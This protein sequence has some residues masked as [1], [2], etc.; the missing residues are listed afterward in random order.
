MQSD[1]VSK[2]A[3]RIHL[4]NMHACGQILMTPFLAVIFGNTQYVY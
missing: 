4:V 1:V 3:E 2:I